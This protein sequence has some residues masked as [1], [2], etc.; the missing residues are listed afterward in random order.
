[1]ELFKKVAS[2]GSK[3]LFKASQHSPALFIAGGLLLFGSAVVVTGVATTKIPNIKEEKNKEKERIEDCRR[4]AEEIVKIDSKEKDSEK[5]SWAVDYL[6]HGYKKEIF[7]LH[8]HVAWRYVKIYLP[9][10]ALTIGGAACVLT[11]HH[12]LNTR[13]T[14]IS[15]A[16]TALQTSY[17]RYR[18]TVAAKYGQEEENKIFEESCQKAIEEL[19]QSIKN[20]ENKSPVADVDLYNA[21]AIR[22]S[23]DNC[24]SLWRNN[25]AANLHLLKTRQCILNDMLN[26]KGYVTVNESRDL[27]DEPPL[28]SGTIFG[29]VKDKND[30]L[31]HNF[32]DIGINP[33]TNPDPELLDFIKTA[34]SPDPKNGTK[35]ITLRFNVDP[36]PIH[37]AMPTH[38]AEMNELFEIK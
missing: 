7:N 18:Q 11:G 5:V 17:S 13:Y 6:D 9:S 37:L 23:K 22:F 4:Q 26:R 30:P 10:A 29:W 19:N 12:I 3:L 27:F 38:T 34:A 24:P 14:K 28:A 15:L 36:V 8:R 25:A 1:M 16:Y 2:V 21:F 33:D 32:I 35:E 20:D 31:R